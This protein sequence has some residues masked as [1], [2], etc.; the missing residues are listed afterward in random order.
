MTTDP[1]HPSLAW[2]GHSNPRHARDALVPKFG[3]LHGRPKR[4]IENIDVREGD[5]ARARELAVQLELTDIISQVFTVTTLSK[6]KKIVFVDN[7]IAAKSK[8]EELPAEILLVDTAGNDL[9]KIE[10][11]D[12]WQTQVLANKVYNFL[13]DISPKF[14]LII[15]NAS[16]SCRIGSLKNSTPHVFFHNSESYNHFL[17]VM[18]DGGGDPTWPFDPLHRIRFNK[19]VQFRHLPSYDPADLMS[20]VSVDPKEVLKDDIHPV[21]APYIQRIRGAIFDY[22]YVLKNLPTKKRKR[23]SRAEK[24][25]KTRK[26]LGIE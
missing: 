16:M 20:K 3:R 26:R 5:N 9:T 11:I 12:H 8:I 13:N 1:A 10:E 18:C 17:E 21:L 23:P 6:D 15:I 25:E 24:S 19:L 22:I 14:K 7:L 4:H 2:A